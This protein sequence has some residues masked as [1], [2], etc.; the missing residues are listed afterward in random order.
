LWYQD[1]LDGLAA[2]LNNNLGEEVTY[3]IIIC[4][5]FEYIFKYHW[6]D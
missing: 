3:A 1:F 6:L 2:T 5:R 4:E